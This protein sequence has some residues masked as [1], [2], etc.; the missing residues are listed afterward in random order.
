MI[1]TRLFNAAM[2]R[3]GHNQTTLAEALGIP[4]STLSRKIN[5]KIPLKTGEK[6]RLCILLSITRPKTAD[7]IFNY[8]PKKDERSETDG[9]L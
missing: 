7:A 3:V 8:D 5:N 1:N 2:A 6:M 9:I 4:Q